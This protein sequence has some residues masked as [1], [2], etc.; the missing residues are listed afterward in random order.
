MSY[1]KSDGTGQYNRDE[2]GGWYCTNPKKHDEGHQ[3]HAAEAEH[4]HRA[5]RHDVDPQR[6]PEA[7]TSARPKP[8]PKPEPIFQPKPEPQPEPE[9]V[10]TTEVE[11]TDDTPKKKDKTGGCC[12]C[13]IFFILLWLLS[14]IF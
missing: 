10:E 11:L 6:N 5:E 3:H 7:R 14:M 1:D 12:G 9:T 8:Q 13:L 4:D 2:R